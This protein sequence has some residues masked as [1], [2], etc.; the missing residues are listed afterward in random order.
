MQSHAVVEAD[1]LQTWPDPNVPRARCTRTIPTL[2]IREQSDVLES[3]I[4]LASHPD[5][6]LHTGTH[7]AV[8]DRA[9]M[10]ACACKS[11]AYHA[12]TAAHGGRPGMPCVHSSRG[13]PPMPNSFCRALPLTDHPP[14]SRA[15]WQ[16]DAACT[17]AMHVAVTCAMNVAVPAHAA[18]ASPRRPRLMQGAA[19][20][21]R[22]HGSSREHDWVCEGSEGYRAQ[23]WDRQTRQGGAGGRRMDS[24]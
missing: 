5:S 9:F 1:T 2:F 6:Q 15:C 14:H 4:C 11:S 20:V 10:H 18:P 17:C 19:Y 24:V 7:C 12:C 23:R 22:W 16:A 21:T 8:A 3:P 13:G